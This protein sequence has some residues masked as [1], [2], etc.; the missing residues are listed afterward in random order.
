MVKLFKEI[1]KKIMFPLITIVALSGNSLAN[2]GKL[3]DIKGI[4]LTSCVNEKICST[5]SKDV[6]LEDIVKLNVVLEGYQ[7]DEK[8]YF[9]D[10]KNIEIKGR[11]ID[12]SIVRS[13]SFK[14]PSIK[15]FK[16]ESEKTDYNNWMGG[17][18]VWDNIK[19]TETLIDDSNNWSIL[20]DAHPS[21]KSRDINDGLGTMR[22]K[23]ELTYGDKK[24]STPGKKSKNSRGIKNNVHRIKLEREIK[25]ID[26]S[27][28]KV[29]IK[30]G[31]YKNKITSIKPE[32][33]DMKKIAEEKNIPLK[34]VYKEV[35]KNIN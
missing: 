9:S 22:Y 27:L 28:G 25:E 35:M 30:I 24:L 31:K 17:N 8:I 11:K 19:Y 4:Y 29:N 3:L 34:D 20:A 18:F 2:Q 23:V 33:E 6:S 12:P 13:W 32:Y 15:W 21:D 5:S 14:D 1:S 16:L 10:E 7:N 26:T